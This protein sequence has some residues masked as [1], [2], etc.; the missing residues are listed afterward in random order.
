MNLRYPLW[1]FSCWITT[2]I[3]VDANFLPGKI[4]FFYALKKMVHVVEKK[5][6]ISLQALGAKMN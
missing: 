4:C 5:K 1:L 3:T 2:F 6:C